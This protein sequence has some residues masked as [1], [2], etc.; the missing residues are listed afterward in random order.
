MVKTISK[1]KEL[2]L[3]F[4]YNNNSTK[5]EDINAKLNIMLVNEDLIKLTLK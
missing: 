1:V 4:Y 2:L 3:K 5:V